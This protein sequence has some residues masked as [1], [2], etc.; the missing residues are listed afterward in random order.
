MARRV[1]YYV[2][3]SPFIS[4]PFP[5]VVFASH[6]PQLTFA[7]NLTL[8]FVVVAA[9]SVIAFII[10]DLGHPGLA[11]WIIQ[12]R[13]G[14]VLLE[15]YLICFTGSTAYAERVISVCRQTL[16]CCGPQISCHRAAHY[17]LHWV[18]RIG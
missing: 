6:L 17:C 3:V 7:S 12:V 15:I 4:H 13:G 11:G 10:R 8:V 18:G 1:G 2:W 5:S 9:G 14:Q 16:R